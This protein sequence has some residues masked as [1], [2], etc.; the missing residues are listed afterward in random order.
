MEGVTM[1]T[2]TGNRRRDG[3]TLVELLVVIAIIGALAGLLAPNIINARRQAARTQCLNNIKGIGAMC[4]SFSQ[5]TKNRG[6]LPFGKGKSPLAYESL[7]TLVDAYKGEL[8]PEQF[9]CPESLDG[10]AEKDESNY[11]TLDEDTCS[12]AYL[13]TKKKNIASS[14]TILVADD[15][16]KDEE[17]GVDENHSDG[18]NVYYLVNSAKFLEKSEE[19][20][21]SDLPKGLVGNSG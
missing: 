1:G 16:V 8:K 21:D 9:V 17:S 5:E 12:Y 13:K 3:F 11:F 15:S 10:I 2:T 14:S 19:F 7:Q 6:L 20:P 4:L 18:V